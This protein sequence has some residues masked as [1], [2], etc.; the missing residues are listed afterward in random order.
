MDKATEND[1]RER[2][3][4]LEVETENQGKFLS[5]IFT[6]LMIGFVSAIGFVFHTLSIRPDAVP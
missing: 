2:I 5:R 4:K 6:L 1:F 3:A